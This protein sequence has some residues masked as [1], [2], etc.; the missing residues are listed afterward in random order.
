[1]RQKILFSVNRKVDLLSLKGYETSAHQS[2]QRLSL[3]GGSGLSYMKPHTPLRSCLSHFHIL[4]HSF[5][6]IETHHCCQIMSKFIRD[7]SFGQFSRVVTRNRILQYPEEQPDFRLQDSYIK[8]LET[9]GLC[10]KDGSLSGSS[11]KE[12]LKDLSVSKYTWAPKFE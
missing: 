5:T 9:A 8:L 6:T 1:M 4:R 11:Q 3:T 2:Q 12:A 7:T 10:S